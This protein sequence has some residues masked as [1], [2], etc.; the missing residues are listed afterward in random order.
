M[1][2]VSGKIEVAGLTESHVIFKYH[3]AADP[4]NTGRVLPFRRDPEAHWFDDYEEALPFEPRVPPGRE[5][6]VLQTV[7]GRC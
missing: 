4:K 6:P 2:H 3:R 7:A 5:L 1:S